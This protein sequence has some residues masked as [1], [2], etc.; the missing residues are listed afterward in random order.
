[1]TLAAGTYTLSLHAAQRNTPQSPQSLEVLVGGNVVGTIQATDTTY[2]EYSVEFTVATGQYTITF[3]GTQA[4]DSTELID[5]LSLSSRVSPARRTPTLALNP[6]PA[7]SVNEGST[8]SFTATASGST[9][10]LTYS[11][12]P[13]APAGAMIDPLTGVFTWTPTVAGHVLGDGPGDRQRLAAP[14][15]RGDRLDHGERRR[16]GRPPG[17]RLGRAPGRDLPR[18]GVLRRHDPRLVRRRRGL[19]RRTG[20]QPLP[21]GPSGTFVLA[22]TY[23]RPGTYTVIVDVRDAFGGVGTADLTLT[24]TAAPLVSGYGVGRDA[25][26]TE[27]YLKDLGRL[28]DPS[29]LKLWS[30]RLANG[31]N[32]R[33]VAR[34]IWGSP[35][36]RML[37][38][39]GLLARIGF[40]RSYRDALV[41]K[42]QTIRGQ[43]PPP[44]G[45]LTL[46]G[47]P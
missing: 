34:Y 11:L 35:E 33:V 17:P 28:P 15:R 30:R 26:V 42:K 8:V 40:E 3:Q 16:P 19:R 6:I 38:K 9:S 7:Q 32:P 47:A 23:T 12:D 46:F 18:D 1:M 27:L 22:H 5:E 10:A 2:R 14:E 41:V 36:H 25:F 29:E 24:A 43:L 4:S 39:S 21:L 45:P 20:L 31:V 44:T 37:V 13:G